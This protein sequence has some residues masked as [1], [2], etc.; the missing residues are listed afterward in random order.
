MRVSRMHACVLGVVLL[1][2]SLSV[3]CSDDPTA[4]SEP[5]LGTVSLLSGDDQTGPVASPL[6]Q[7]LVVEVL[8]QDGEPMAD[9]LV[10]F[11]V[12]GGAGS[13]AE[14]VVVSDDDGRAS[15]VWTLG[16]STAD[17]QRVEVRTVGSE[18]GQVVHGVFTATPLPGPTA[19]IS[20]PR[21]TF[22]FGW[23]GDTAHVRAQARD[24]FGNLVPSAPI[25]YRIDGDMGAISVDSVTGVVTAVQPGSQRFRATLGSVADTARAVVLPVVATIDPVLDS[26][27]A[28][29]LHDTILP[30]VA[31]LD[32][33]GSA[34]TAAGTLRWRALDPTIVAVTDSLTGA[35]VT[36]ANGVG[37]I[38]VQAATG[39]ARDTIVVTVAQAIDIVVV[40]PPARV[41]A[42]GDSA[43]LQAFARDA[44]DV[45]VEGVV[46][47]WSSADAARVAVSPSGMVAALDY[48][49]TRVS[50]SAAGLSAGADITVRN[51]DTLTIAAVAG[52]GQAGV[53]GKPLALAL[54]TRVT[55]QFGESIPGVAIAWWSDAGV[56]VTQSQPTTDGAGLN[57]ASLVLDTVAGIQR[58]YATIGNDTVTFSFI[59]HADVAATFA[60]ASAQT[61]TDTVGD[62]VPVL[63]R[64][65]V[66]DRY[67]NGVPGLQ[68]EFSALNGSVASGTVQPT[69]ADGFATV[70]TWQLD[71]V[72]GTDTLV[73]ALADTLDTSFAAL[74]FDAAVV[75]DSASVLRSVIAIG[76]T[77][78]ESLSTPVQVQLV[79]RYG[80]PL[81]ASDGTVTL[82]A[83]AG[84]FAAVTDNGNGTWSA[85][86]V[87]GGARGLFH[88]YARLDGDSIAS[89]DSTLSRSYMLTWLG[90][91][92]T[93]FMDPANWS[94]PG[95]PPSP[96]DTVLI[97]TTNAP[98]N[99][100]ALTSNT[101]VE[102]VY[103]DV[104]A[105]IDGAFD[106]TVTRDYE[107]GGLSGGT[108]MVTGRLL[109][110]GAV[111]A[112][113]GNARNLR[114]TGR[115]S[116]TGN[117]NVT[118]GRIVVQ[119]GRLRNTGFR[120]RV[121]PQ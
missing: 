82:H 52:N 23:L 109:M 36:L 99:W 47:E 105:Q 94:A 11:A 2:G 72:P 3:S 117:V 111:A 116:L 26:I 69:A 67:G 32:S 18:G 106:L 17:S 13:M 101:T 104:G 75:P 40:T 78:R 15:D 64:V 4:P 121:R 34:I 103:Y 95:G 98:P 61:Q 92:G 118:G 19:T 115:A 107:G 93:D 54:Q 8:D 79:D 80:N 42:I 22:A 88:L 83:P 49:V 102:V 71:T 53:V 100:P 112:L 50:A 5:E 73:A 110:T 62:T 86:Y 30:Q 1:S 59:A 114:I 96:N 76:D 10:I 55:N 14:G 56:A 89:R 44:N 25:R 68:V 63:P 37:R 66:T 35:S 28:T 43:Q 57:Q 31:A 90:T 41:V 16:T 20:I 120:I 77:V 6:A 45:V 51:P 24:R 84:S 113:H 58:V 60:V 85:S 97:T 48:G 12:A 38:E 46:F 70:T 9:V 108:G 21:D 119:G 39:A 29:A 91:A 81:V 74:V 65:R 33:G 27:Q 7:P 87:P